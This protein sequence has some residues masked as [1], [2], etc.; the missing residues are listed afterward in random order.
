MTQP[1]EERLETA[2]SKLGLREPFVA[3]VVCKLQ[4]IVVDGDPSFTA[5]TN[6]VYT[7]YGR[8][9]CDK[10]DDEQLFGLAFHEALHV[11]LMHMWRREDREPGLWNTANDAIINCMV[12]AKGYKLPADGVF[13]PWVTESHD[14]E[15]V[16]IKLRD[17]RDKRKQQGDKGKPGDPGEAQKGGWDNQGDLEDAPDAATQADIE[18]TIL[19]A[20]RMAR[21]CGDTS[22]LIDRVLG[23]VGK[24]EIAWQD[25]V[26]VMLRS[27]QRNDFTYRRFSRRFVSRG[28]YLPAL[29]SESIGGLGIGFDTSG[30]VTDAMAQQLGT[31]IQAIVDDLDPD[32][33]EV[34][35]CDTTIG[36]TQRFER[37]EPIE[38]KPIGGGGT[39][40]RP[41]FDYF[42]DKD[43]KVAGLIYLTDMEGNLDE[44]DEPEF[45]VIWGNVG[46]RGQEAPFGKVVTIRI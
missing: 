43:E 20:A 8:V 25:E 2:Y 18:A 44:C 27:A 5:A 21:E 14:S 33:V 7:K 37:G 30:S 41:V 23:E 46:H 39:R 38:L 6:G 1:L 42:E 32:W 31:E 4:R 12:L 9:W 24:S 29:Y 11:I 36:G 3:A 10:Q 28:L 40:F 17:Q 35:F 45:P 16:Y 13:I 15:G 19:A 22:A 26:R 34:V